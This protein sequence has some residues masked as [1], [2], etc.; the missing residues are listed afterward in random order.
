MKK[1]SI[2]LA[3]MLA[4]LILLAGWAHSLK[5]QVAYAD[6]DCPVCGSDEVLDFGESELGQKCHCYDCKTEFYITENYSDYE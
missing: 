1:Q 2:L 4:K 5:A 3:V 6:I